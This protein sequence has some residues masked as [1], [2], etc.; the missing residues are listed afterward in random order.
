MRID[1]VFDSSRSAAAQLERLHAGVESLQE[2]VT[3]AQ[4]K[5]AMAAAKRKG[6]ST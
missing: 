6:A 1:L 2:F 3:A 4:V 5:E